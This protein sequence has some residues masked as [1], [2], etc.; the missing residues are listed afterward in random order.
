MVNL[1]CSHNTPSLTFATRGSIV[2]RN[3]HVQVPSGSCL[4]PLSSAGLVLA[5]AAAASRM[6]RTIALGGRSGSGA[7]RPRSQPT[8]STDRIF[9]I[10]TPPPRVGGGEFCGVAFLLAVGAALSGDDV[11]APRLVC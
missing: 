7:S 6:A 10:F 3:R 1:P 2:L 4:A 11:V 5:V 9:S 8:G